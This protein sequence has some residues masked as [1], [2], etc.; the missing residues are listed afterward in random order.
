VNIDYDAIV[1][2]AGPAGSATG[3]DIAAHGF[4][5]LLIEEHEAVGEPLHCAGLVTPR[6]LELAGVADGLIINE[7]RGGFVNSPLGTRLP[8]GGDRLRAVAIQRQRLDELLAAAAQQA[9]AELRTSARLIAL[10]RQPGALVV[11]LRSRGRPQ[12]LRTRLLIGADGA[13]SRVGRWL[14]LRARHEERIV[15]LGLEARLETERQDFLEIFVGNSIAPG[16]FGW[17]IPLG[18]GRA[19]IGVATSD[20]RRPIHYLGRLLEAF[21]RLFADAQFGRLYGGVIPLRRPHRI[22]C[23]NAMLVG[24]AAGQVKPTSGGGIYTGLVGA[25]HCAQA[26]VRALT[27][28]DLSVASLARYQKAWA[29][30]MSRELARGWDLRRIFLALD[31]RELDGL[32]SV[33]RSQRLRRLAEQ[34][35]DIDFPSRLFSRLPLAVPVLRPFLRTALRLLGQRARTHWNVPDTRGSREAPAG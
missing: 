23:E 15:G 28:D 19:R 7:L 13:Q 18:G 11:H 33:F 4:R 5:T 26:A 22:Y 10:E 24:D 32:V 3:R 14:G 17:V 35:G 6:T 12:A 16:F 29:G 8:L 34:H 31:D 21:P 2:G 27:E 20:G 9:G 25:K 1:V 30:E